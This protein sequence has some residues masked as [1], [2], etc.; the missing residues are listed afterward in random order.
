MDFGSD[1]WVFQKVKQ[2]VVK[3]NT[4]IK[5]PIVESNPWEQKV[6]EIKATQPGDELRGDSPLH[7]PANYS[8]PNVD[9]LKLMPLV[10]PENT[11][12]QPVRRF[13]LTR[14]SR[15]KSQPPINGVRKR[16]AEKAVATFKERIPPS[17]I[18]AALAGKE[19]DTIKLHTPS[20]N[21]EEKLDTHM[22][23]SNGPV[24]TNNEDKTDVPTSI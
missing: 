16:H 20:K 9:R 23:I 7:R 5:P 12:S 22:P 19:S 3:E 15:V 1:V 4:P 8:A 17:V 11:I 21:P 18:E 10:L 24:Q 2:D 6:P 14:V 13:H